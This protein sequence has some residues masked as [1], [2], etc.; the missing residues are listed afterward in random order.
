MG[1]TICGPGA[2]DP[3]LSFQWAKGHGRRDN[4]KI[5]V[6]DPSSSLEEKGKTAQQTEGE[7]DCD[8]DVYKLGS[9]P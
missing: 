4:G 2:Q 5:A 3:N 6:T 1:I 9:G 8:F 7:T